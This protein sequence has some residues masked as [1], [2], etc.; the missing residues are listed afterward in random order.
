M[1]CFHPPDDLHQQS[2]MSSIV[3]AAKDESCT[4][5]MEDSLADLDRIV[6]RDRQSM[7]NS[8]NAKDCKLRELNLSG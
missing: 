3:A 1:T 2:E 7:A 6:E 8:I 4:I 5:K